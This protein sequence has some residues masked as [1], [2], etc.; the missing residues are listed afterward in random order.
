MRAYP[1]QL[2][3]CASGALLAAA[4]VL[5]GCA[6]YSD[7]TL[8]ARN[9]LDAGRPKQALELFNEELEVDSAEQLPADLAGDASLLLLSRSMVLQELARYELSSRDLETCDKLIE[10]LD[11]SRSAVDDIGKYLFSDDVGPYKAPPYEKLMINTVNM[12]NYLARADLNGARIEARRLAVMQK[13]LEDNEDPAR[14]LVGAGSYLAG[15]VNEKS[16]RPQEALRYYDEALRYGDYATLHEPIRRLAERASYR[17]PRLQKVLDAAAGAELPN[18]DGQSEV[19]VIASYGRVPAKVAKRIP[20]GLALTYASGALSPFDRERANK[21]ALQGLVTWVNFPAMGKP[22]GQWDN[23]SAALSGRDVL[24]EGI[25]AIDREAYRAFERTRGSVV[26]SAITRMIA[27]VL[28]GQA[29]NQAGGEGGIGLLLSLA[30][31][32]T[33]TAT[34]TP[35]TRS[36]ETLPARMAFGRQWVPAGAHAVT[37]SAR[38]VS[39][40]AELRLEPGGWAAVPLTVLH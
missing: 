1:R 32:A 3:T 34:D 23:P 25:V 7:R 13:Y 19:F 27:R 29:A 4:L 20:I 5:G 26:A 36:W 18:R 22:R 40:R 33:L 17:S 16:G 21:L 14:A 28:A 31:Q 39:R 30:T 37:V 15:F 38:G 8:E 12:V 24:L 35:D 10:L 11:F 2:Q 9:A 6:G